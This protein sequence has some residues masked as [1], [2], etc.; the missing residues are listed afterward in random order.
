MSADKPE[1]SGAR[2][3]RLIAAA[4]LFLIG[5]IIGYFLGRWLAMPH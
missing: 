2:Q 4:E 1:S 3:K 5:A